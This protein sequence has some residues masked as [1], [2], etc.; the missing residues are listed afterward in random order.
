MTTKKEEIIN[1]RPIKVKKVQLEI[2]GDTPL[3]MHAWSEKAKRMMLEAQ[4]G[5][6]K[7]KTKAKKNPVADFVDSMYWLTE[8]P[9]ITAD[10]TEE[11][12]EKAFL[13]AV[14]HGARFGFPVTAFKQA[15]TAAAY[16]MGWVKNQAALR[17]SF[18]IEADENGMI[19]IK[20]DVPVIREDMVRIGQGTS[21]IRYR[22]EFRNW[23][24]TLT[25]SYNEEGQFSLE[26]I[27]NVIN[28]GGY[29]CGVGEWRPEKD[30]QYGMY[31]VKANK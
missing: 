26:N 14:G 27:V 10:M 25:V 16:R 2:V 17:G 20:S 8:K 22:G 9:E 12:S 4:Q 24:A 28:A 1:I 13:E 19:E 7:G 31:H 15:G 6:A 21:D 3:I 11:E 30:G 23:S 18:F 5:K 29:A